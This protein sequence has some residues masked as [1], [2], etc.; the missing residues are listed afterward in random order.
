MATYAVTGAR[1]GMG[2]AVVDRLSADGHRVITVDI[3]E[4]D[5]VADL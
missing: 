2:R 5:V 1:S 4:A 3:A